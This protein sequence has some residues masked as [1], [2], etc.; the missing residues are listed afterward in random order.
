MRFTITILV[1]GL[2]MQAAAAQDFLAEQKRYPRVRDAISKKEAVIDRTL[3][4][5]GLDKGK[6]EIIITAYK[7]EKKLEI[8]ARNRGDVAYRL[9]A[10]YDI[11]ATSGSLGPKRRQGDRQIP[12]GFYRIEHFNPASSYHLSMSINYPN[13][14]DRLK[15]N[16]ADLGGNICIHGS[17]VTIG[18]LPMTDD[19]IKEIYLYAVYARSGGQTDIPVYIFPF[20]MDAANCAKYSKKYAADTKLISFWKNLKTG[21]NKFILHKSKLAIS[22]AAN[23]DYVFSQQ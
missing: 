18:C 19:K 7:A 1:M 15:S 13:R 4:A 11:C 5:A 2:F 12:E 16:A 3:I 8:Y 21:Y 9:L 22:F 17:C 6:L 10:V 20:R 23:G 14:S